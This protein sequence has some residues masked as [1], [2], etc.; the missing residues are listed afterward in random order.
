MS[1]AKD[2]GLCNDKIISV[3]RTNGDGSPGTID[4]YTITLRSGS[5]YTFNV[6]NGNEFDASPANIFPTLSALESAYPTGDGHIYVVS[7][8]GHWYYWNGN[9]W[10]DGGV[11]QAILLS[12]EDQKCV[13][14]ALLENRKT[15]NLSNF[16]IIKGD[17]ASKTLAI[18]N[19]GTYT[20]EFTNDIRAYFDILSGTTSIQTGFLDA[21][22]HKIVFDA[23]NDSALKFTQYMQKEYPISSD[24]KL[25]LTN[26]YNKVLHL[27]DA[28][29]KQSMMDC[30]DWEIQGSETSW[31]YRNT[32]ELRINANPTYWQSILKSRTFDL[33]NVDFKK[34]TLEFDITITS[35]A[36]FYLG[37]TEVSRVEAGQKHFKYTFYKNQIS[38]G[39]LRNFYLQFSCGNKLTFFISN[40]CFY[41]NDKGST[42]KQQVNHL[43][44]YEY[45]LEKIIKDGGLTRALK[46]IMCIGDSLTEGVFDYN[47]NGHT[48]WAVLS[49]YSYPE[50]MKRILGN[51]VVNAGNGG[52]NSKTWYNSMADTYL[53]SARNCDA[54]II[55]LGTNDIGDRGDFV[56]NVN[57]DINLSDYN[58]NADNSVGYY[59]R[60]IQRIKSINPKAKIFC[61]TIPNTRN[62]LNRYSANEKIRNIANLLKCYIIDLQYYYV[63]EGE[64][65]NFKAKYYNGGHLNA[66]GYLNLAYTFISYIDYI[67]NTNI[68]DFREIHFI[69]TD[70]YFS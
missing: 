66:L 15:K 14:F 44:Y 52:T 18:L 22:L 24:I 45:P 1:N 59:A 67:I 42:F 68:S 13:D 30:Y 51:T 48:N 43:N 9:D 54:Y 62:G 39:E 34:I 70:Y 63:D 61:V 64:V 21:G 17:G 37:E 31:V 33:S 36:T 55:A 8:N 32:K 60:I 12:D 11:Y 56:G 16:L 27:D 6:T 3:E 29:P 5:T 26:D 47:D 2:L 23:T 58:N 35:G 41:I 50:Q 69:G 65:Y 49:D 4:T 46:S 19:K 10:T 40:I 38:L 28:Y 53:V 7:A 20:L 57:T 25:Y